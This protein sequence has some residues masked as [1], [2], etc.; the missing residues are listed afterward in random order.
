MHVKRRLNI[1]V[2]DSVNFLPM[3]LPEAFGFKELKKSFFPHKFKHRANWTY[4]NPYHAAE[5]YSPNYNSREER[6]EF[7]SWH[8]DKVERGEHFDFKKEILECVEAT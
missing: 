8:Q 5:F 1:N 6:A 4:S 7:L 3:K 2:L